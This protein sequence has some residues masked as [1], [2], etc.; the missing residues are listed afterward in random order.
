MAQVT[1]VAQVQSL[2]RELLHA[3]GVAKKKKKKGKKNRKETKTK[4]AK[5]IFRKNKDE[6]KTPH[7]FGLY[8]KATVIKTAWYGFKNSI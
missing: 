1:V 2:D 8:Y 5:A 4:I 6:G 7:D 3:A